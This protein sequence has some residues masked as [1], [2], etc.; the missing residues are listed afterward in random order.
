MN[1][2]VYSFDGKIM[3][4]KGKGCIGDE[5]IGVIACIIMIWWSRKF[6]RKLQ[7]LKITNDL[8]KIY[9]DDI[10]GVYGAIKS[11]AKFI[12]GNIEYD[13]DDENNDALPDDI[14]TMIV[15]RDIANS[16]EPMITVTTDVPSN[17]DDGKVPML[18]VKVWLESNKEIFYQFYEKPTKNRY[19]ISK[20]SA[21]PISK[22]IDTLSQEV[23]RRLHNTKKEISWSVKTDILNKFMS[24]LKASGYSQKD[25]QEILKSGV[26]R[27]N[28]LRGQEEEGTRPFFRNK[29]FEKE[30]RRNLKEA[31]KGSWFR[32]KDNKFTSVFFVAPT[33]NS[34]LMKML[35]KTEDKFKVGDSDRIKFVETS[36]RKYLDFFKSSN[37]S[38][39]RCETSENCLVCENS[40]SGTNCKAMNI[41]YSLRC[42]LCKQRNRMVSYE[43]ESARS[44]F[45]RSRKHQNDLKRKSKN[46]VML[47]HIMNEHMNEQS[48]VNFE[49]KI[50]GKFTSSLSRQID[51]SWRI[52]NKDPA[53]LLN[54]KSEFYGPCI[55]RKV[56]EK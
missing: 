21:M 52:R 34:I 25:R 20:D 56:L 28:K 32:K 31:K 27:Y 54:S 46:S 19:V 38:T 45:L 23:F 51:E 16:I 2:H 41:G 42:K 15:I 12:N 5:A 47:K 6:K 10:N 55:K 14:R 37:V 18:D 44:G 30:K 22:K 39:A 40:K 50:V 53:L 35:Q 13:E 7:Y 26:N 36:G 43:G 17:H 1:N 3:L 49:M 29:H 33:P 24:E 8:L 48:N 4:Q 11:G 9:V